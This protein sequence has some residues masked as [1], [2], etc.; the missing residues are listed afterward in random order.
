MALRLV[1]MN[2]AGIT[3]QV[4]D[5]YTESEEA[6]DRISAVASPVALSPVPPV[7]F[8]ERLQMPLQRPTR[9][10]VRR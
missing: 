8:L 10:A 3:D 4:K 7:L 5:E 2:G 1:N 6:A 9:S